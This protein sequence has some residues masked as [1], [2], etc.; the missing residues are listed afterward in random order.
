MTQGLNLTCSV[1]RRSE[2]RNAGGG[3]VITNSTVATGVRCRLGNAGSG[4][5][6][7]LQGQGFETNHMH[8]L[9]IQP[10]TVDVREDD[11]ITMT[12]GFYSG[13]QFVV[14]LVKFDSLPS[15]DA[16]SHI[17]LLVERIVK[18]RVGP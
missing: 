15:T 4:Q 8:E 14:R 6:M 11:Y 2:S 3:V 13:N 1:T 18:A 9:M 5:K 10:S 7:A 12:G 17:E 16:R